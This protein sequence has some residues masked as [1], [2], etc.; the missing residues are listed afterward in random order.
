[1]QTILA[2]AALAVVMTL[3]LTVHRQ[4][5]SLVERG[6]H[7]EVDTVAL[8]V[9]GERLNRA[10][11]LPFDSASGVLDVGQ[12][13]APADFGGAAAWDAAADLDDVHGLEEDVVVTA[14]G[15]SLPYTVQHEVLYVDYVGGALSAATGPTPYKELTVT[16]TGADGRQ[17]V[18]TRVY[19][20]FFNA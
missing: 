19:N 7:N 3:G 11:N 20:C 17:A 15:R 16:V 4:R 8:G 14:H 2:I 6:V 9:A 5:A 10:S 12:L 18:L 1:M 13:T